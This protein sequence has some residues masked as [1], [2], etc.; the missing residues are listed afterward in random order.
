MSR[1]PSVTIPLLL[2]ALSV[3]LVAYSALRERAPAP[4]NILFIVLDDLGVNDLGFVDPSVATPHLDA[5]AAEGTYYSRHYTDATCSVTRVGMLTGQSAAVHGFRT[6]ARGLSP[7]IVT[8]PDVLRGAGYAT[9]HVGKWHLGHASRLAWPTAHGFDGY[10]GFLDQHFLQAPSRAG[11]WTIERPGY[12]NPWLMRNNE[13][14]TQHEGH[15]TDLLTNEAIS[16]LK[17][18]EES[19]QPWFLNL[20]L[21]TPH[22]PIEPQEEF[23]LS[24]PDTPEGRYLAMLAGADAAIGRVLQA[25]EASGQG[26]DTLVIVASDNGGTNQY[27]DN[28]AP[29]AGRKGSFAEGGV[30]AP[31]L[32]RW[33]GRVPP[34]RTMDEVVTYLDYLPT[35]ANVA[36]AEV[37]ST[38]V[39]RNLLNDDALRAPLPQHLFWEVSSGYFH[40]WGILSNDKRWRLV[41]QMFGPAALYDLDA[42]PGAHNNVMSEH[43]DVAKALNAAYIDWRRKARRVPV[44]HAPQP[45]GGATL[46]G[47]TMQRVPGFD[48]HTIGVAVHFEEP[49]RPSME[50]LLHQPQQWELV[51]EDQRLLLSMNGIHLD[52]PVPSGDH[53]HS[54]IIT[55]LFHE[56]HIRKGNDYSMVTLFIDGM[57]AASKRENSFTLQPDAFEAP[58]Y[59][60]RN[61]TGE[62]L[63]SGRLGVPVVLNEQLLPDSANSRRSGREVT[64]LHSELCPK[65]KKKG[66]SIDEP[67]ERPPNQ[68]GG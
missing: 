29:L 53:C 55:S 43:A 63:F 26:D 28:N 12:R 5:L 40:G 20:W 31:L 66:A 34:G 30:R 41:T 50:Y 58:T 21:Y 39:G 27:R 15:L 33:P 6:T 42:D 60:G 51:R 64:T 8:L 10:F 24:H 49:P 4:P 59:I 36:G 2:V 32:V 35:L 61:A 9:H 48:A 46:S 17:E 13:A 54:I 3:L 25:L 38:L 68:G 18:R 37:P 19:S 57:P 22:S 52:A 7:D 23:A 47:H 14:P 16:F 1:S 56:A 62:G 44:T 45:G 67:P 11:E 65:G